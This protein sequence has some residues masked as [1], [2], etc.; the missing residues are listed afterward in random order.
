MNPPVE[1][2]PPAHLPARRSARATR[3]AAVVVAVAAATLV[4]WLMIAVL[5]RDPRFVP[6]LR[7][8]NPSGYDIRLDIAAVDRQSRLPLGVVGQHCTSAFEDV[9]DPGDTWV[10]RFA[11]QGRD[12]GAVTVSRSQLD[13]DGWTIRV[14]DEVVDRLRGAGA[15]PAPRH[16]CAPE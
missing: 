8:D 1:I 13:A 10:V 4:V 14:P 7:V 6:R 9:I 15:P 3:I 5:L 16:S 11:A 12:G 2:R